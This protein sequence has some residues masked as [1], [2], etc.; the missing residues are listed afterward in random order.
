MPARDPRTDLVQL[1]RALKVAV[2]PHE[3]TQVAERIPAPGTR[4][5][6][7]ELEEG[8][9]CLGRNGLGKVFHLTIPELGTRS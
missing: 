7:P 5:N 1:S 4:E 9:A 6:V 2:N 8:Y 3:R